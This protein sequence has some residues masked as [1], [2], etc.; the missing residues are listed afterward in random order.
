MTPRIALQAS[1]LLASFAASLLSPAALATGDSTQRQSGSR[2]SLLIVTSIPPIQSLV[3]MVMSDVADPRALLSGYESPHDFALRPS[4]RRLL[5]DADLVVWIDDH[6]EGAIA[7][8]MTGTSDGPRSLQ[9]SAVSTTIRHHARSI[10]DEHHHDHDSR[11]LDPHMWLDPVNARIWVGAIAEH[12][13]RIDPDNAN[14]YGRNAERAQSRLRELEKTL[15]DQLAPVR[16]ADFLAYHDA[17]QYFEHRF[18]LRRAIALTGHE[19]VAPG[20]KR[21]AK[22]QALIRERRISCIFREPQFSE[23]LLRTMARDL[24]GTGTLAIRIADPVGSDLAPGKHQY[25]EMLLRLSKAFVDCL[26]RQ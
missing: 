20:A 25:F 19:A 22:L 15:A 4:H 8:I 16:D 23:K 1:L 6:L 18:G 14:V 10:D 5:A 24:R 21:I 3:A 7:E 13:S 11:H 17:Y 12:L 9:L 26:D 2:E